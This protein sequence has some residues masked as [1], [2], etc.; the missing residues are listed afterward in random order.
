VK[1]VDTLDLGS[2]AAMRAGSSPV[3]GIFF[4]MRPIADCKLYGILDLGYVKREKVVSTTQQLLDGGVNVLQ[5]R[6]KGFDPAV[7]ESMALEMLPLTRDAGTP[8][9]I[10]DFPEI[11]A[12]VGA[13]GI[14]VGQDDI[15][16]ARVR[17]IVGHEM[18]VG[19]SSHSLDQAR[20]AAGE[21]GV[22]YIGFGPIFATPTKPTY[23]PI[24]MDDIAQVHRDVS[25]PIFCIGGIKLENVERILEAGARRVVI[26]SG[27]LQALDIPAYIR[28]VRALIDSHS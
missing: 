27:I 18:L 28:D 21:A 19:K 3:P 24:G 23:I 13:D 17:E 8:L 6:A 7:I 26:V 12:K 14:H 20:A 5:L 25:I 10:N 11:A 16:I 9:I 22:D 15:K 2:S 4:F 1:L